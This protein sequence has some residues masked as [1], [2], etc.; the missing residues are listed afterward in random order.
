MAAEHRAEAMKQLRTLVS[1][2]TQTGL[3]HTDLQTSRIKRDE[4]D[5]TAIEDMLENNWTNPFSTQPSDLVNIST[6]AA[7]TPAITKDLLSA[8][9]KGNEAFK[10]FLGKLESANIQP[11]EGYSCQNW[12][13]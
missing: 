7:A 9:D 10:T 11:Y 4:S 2:C 1:A 8:F 12:Y 5:V 13:K 6:G 3:G